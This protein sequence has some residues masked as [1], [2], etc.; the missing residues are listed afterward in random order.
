M[1]AGR[2]RSDGKLERVL[3]AGSFAVTAETSPTATTDRFAPILRAA[4]LR[5]RADAINITDGAGARAHLSSLVVAGLLVEAGFEPIL[6]FTCRDRNRLALQGDLLGAAAVGVHSILCLTGDAPE[7]GD[8]PETKGVF[9]IGSAEL[10][11]LAKRLRD[12]GTLGSGRKIAG[13]PRLFIG[14]ADLPLDPPADWQPKSLLAKIDAGTDFVQTQYCFDMARC[15][16]YMERLGE[17]GVPDRLHILIG[18][19]PLKSARQ[20]RWMR[21]N[22]YGVEIPDAIVDRLEGAEDQAAEGI[23]ICVELIQELREIEGVAGA[24]LMA[25]QQEAACARAIEDS[26]ILKRRP[27]D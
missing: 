1:T 3:R 26:G 18:I 22:L 19:G 7:S 2:P 17:F 23:R 27:V 14:G 12:E 11:A 25:P 6:Q 16:R 20:A 4:P 21:E 10:V 5:D 13:Q 8:E 15:R 9:D 24:H